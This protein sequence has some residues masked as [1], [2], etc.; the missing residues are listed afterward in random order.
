MYKITESIDIEETG[1]RNVYTNETR[2]AK[3]DQVSTKNL[4]IFST[5]LYHN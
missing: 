4:T 2:P 3:K 5:L 1:F